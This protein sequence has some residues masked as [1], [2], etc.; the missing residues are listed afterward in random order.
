VALGAGGIA[1]GALLTQ[2]I[3]IQAKRVRLDRELFFLGDARLAFFYHGIVEFLDA[4][5][6]QAD[7]MVVVLALVQ[8]EYRL[9]RVEDM[10][11]KKSGVF[12]LQEDAINRRQADV[13]A[14]ALEL[15]IDIF[16]AKMP[17]QLPFLRLLEQVKNLQARDCK[18]ET[19]F[20]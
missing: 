10:A 17:A 18:L 20:L 16:G 11:L 4:T 8:L 5:A 2:A 7:K 13:L 1:V 12:K 14:V 15:A 6:L 3:G 19:G 9:P